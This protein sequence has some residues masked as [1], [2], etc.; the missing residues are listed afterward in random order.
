[1]ALFSRREDRDDDADELFRVY[2]LFLAKLKLNKSFLLLKQNIVQIVVY[3]F[4]DHHIWIYRSVLLQ[5]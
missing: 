3:S 1:M 4:T 5:M 2:F